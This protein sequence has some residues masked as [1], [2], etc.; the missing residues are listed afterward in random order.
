MKVLLGLGDFKPD[1]NARSWRPGG[2]IASLAAG[3]Q[4]LCE[5]EEAD[6]FV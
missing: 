5:V 4:R 3:L 6:S 2:M 1:G